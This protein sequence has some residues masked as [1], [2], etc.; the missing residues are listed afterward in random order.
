MRFFFWKYGEKKCLPFSSPEPKALVSFSNANLS[1]VVVINFSNFY[2]LLQN[3]WAT[4]TKLCT[5][6]PWRKGFQVCSKEGSYPLQN[7]ERVKI[8][9]DV[10]K[11]FFSRTTTNFNQKDEFL[12]TGEIFRKDWRYGWLV[13]KN[14][15]L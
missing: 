9:L 15:F 2:L 4:K 1:V 12:F 5:K 3:H 7:Q 13:L 11:I 8:G 14:L 6:H 10:L